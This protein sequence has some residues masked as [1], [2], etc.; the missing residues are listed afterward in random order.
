MSVTVTLTVGVPLSLLLKV[1]TSNFKLSPSTHAHS[2]GDWSLDL[3]Q[4]SRYNLY[5]RLTFS[6]SVKRARFVTLPSGLYRISV[7][8]DTC[9]Y[10]TEFILGR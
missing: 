6:D 1:E 9:V 4:S 3:S 7:V 5:K 8:S 10:R 2:L